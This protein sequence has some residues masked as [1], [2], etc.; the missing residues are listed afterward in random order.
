V[1]LLREAGLPASER[2]AG[3]PEAHVTFV[4]RHLHEIERI[5]DLEPAR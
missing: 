5:L 2:P 3:V 4:E 1:A